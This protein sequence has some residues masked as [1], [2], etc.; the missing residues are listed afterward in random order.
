MNKEALQQLEEQ[1]TGTIREWIKDNWYQPLDIS[2]GNFIE[3]CR[4]YGSE[5]IQHIYEE[6][7]DGAPEDDPE[8]Q[9]ALLRLERKLS[10][11]QTQFVQKKHCNNESTTYRQS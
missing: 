3:H 9:Q 6:V 7:W 4:M 11:I 5:D 8:V 2:E 10:E 1:C